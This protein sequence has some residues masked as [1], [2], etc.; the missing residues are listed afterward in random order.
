MQFWSLNSRRLLSKLM[1]PLTMSSLSISFSCTD[2]DF[3]FFSRITDTSAKVLSIAGFLY[4]PGDASSERKRGDS[5]V[6]SKQI[7]FH[8]LKS[9]CSCSVVMMVST[10]IALMAYLAGV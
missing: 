5:L 9:Q 3:N 2:S 4:V 7:V 8:S 1:G 10:E 6:L